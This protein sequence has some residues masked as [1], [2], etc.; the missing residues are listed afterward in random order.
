MS[1]CLFFIFAILLIFPCFASAQTT[2]PVRDPKLHWSFLPLRAVAIP[3]VKNNAWVK[4]P[5]DAFVQASLEENGLQPSPGADKRTLIRRVYYDLT[6]LPPTFEEVTAFENDRSPDAYAKVVEQLLASQRY[7]ERWGRYWLDLARYA[8]TKGYVYADREDPRFVGSH[9][10]RDWVINAFN[11]DLPYDQFIKLQIAADQ[12]NCPREDLAA[13]G[14]LTVGRRFLGVNHDII[15]DRIDVVTR[16][17]QGLSVACA[18]CHDHK[19]DPIPTQDYYSLYGVFDASTEKLLPLEAEPKPQSVQYAAYKAELKKRTDKLNKLFAQKCEEVADRAR[20]RSV[21]YLQAVLEVEK[22]PD[23]LFYINRDGND[24]YPVMVRQWQQHIRSQLGGWS[25]VWGPWNELVQIPAEQFSSAAPYVIQRFVQERLRYTNHRVVEALVDAKPASMRDVAAIYGNLLIQAD[26]QWKDLL[27]ADP[28]AERLGD[29]DW[30]ELRQELYAADSPARAPKGSV[31]D[32]EFFFDEGTRVVLAKAQME[33]EKW[34]IDAPG[35]TPQAMVLEDRP[36]QSNPHVFKRGNPMNRGEEVPR[37]YLQIVAGPN[38]KPFTQGSGR[39]EMAEAIASKS[40][41]LTARVMVNRIW[42]WH[43]GAGLVSTPSDLG[44]RC[45][46]PTHPE[47]LDCLALQFMDKGWSI[48]AMHRLILLSSTYQQAG[49]DNDKALAIDP[50]NHLLWRMLPQRLGFEEL[51]DSLLAVNGQLDLTV[52]GKPVEL[53]KAPFSSRR[54]VYGRV[55]R[56][57]LPGTF[58]VFDFANPDLHTPQRPITT[59]PQ[60]ALFMMNSAFVV[61]RARAIAA[62]PAIAAISDPEARIARLYQMIYQRNPSAAETAVGVDYVNHAEAD[63]K[64]KAPPAIS[65]AWQYGYG[66]FDAATG[67]VK[68]FAPLP[69]FNG[70]AW[71]GGK[72]W[73]DAKLGWA[74]LTAT[75]GHAGNDL[76]HAV[77]RRWISPM[78]GVVSIS[79]TLAHN[80]A[81]GEGI[82]ARIVSSRQGQLQEWTL[83]NKKGKTDIKSLDVKKGDTIDFVVSIAQSLNNNDFLWAPVIKAAASKENWNAHNDFGGPFTAPKPLSPWESYVQALLLANEFVFVD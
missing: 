41:P 8:D 75:G 74:Q 40:N 45:D 29:G 1:L 28:K 18:R 49:E 56:Q 23:E 22:L 79:G 31:A 5:I 21:Q 78:D 57:F 46:P 38:R 30:E 36:V 55:D 53:F 67:R 37:R 3:A 9:N 33:I 66:E 16:T 81:E 60:Q 54:A 19:F 43:F 59:V 68:S 10:Y 24:I 72:D 71:Q 27:K 65:T 47:L 61:E 58:R 25:R 80:H 48:K 14:F 15:D 4:T 34:Q 51:R 11:R 6:G 26:R 35:A 12:M 83:H 13:M 7:G 17:M 76:Q 62:H 52:G 82:I 63:P 32:I 2:S 44:M 20:A 64:P 77:I 73:P 42:E 39:L 70:T 69:Y 50:E